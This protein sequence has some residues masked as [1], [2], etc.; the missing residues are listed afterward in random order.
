M[1]TSG[2][3]YIATHTLKWC[4]KAVNGVSANL[5]YLPVKFITFIKTGHTIESKAL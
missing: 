3:V 2:Y 1:V 5:N 4:S